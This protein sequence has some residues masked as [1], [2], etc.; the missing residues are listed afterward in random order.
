MKPLKG[1]L[2]LSLHGSP[3]ICTA[4]TTAF[5]KPR[6][7]SDSRYALVGT[8][9]EVRQACYPLTERM[10]N[11]FL[12]NLVTVLCLVAF[13]VQAMAGGL[14]VECREA[15]GTSHLEWGGCG[16]DDTGRCFAPCEPQESSDDSSAPRPCEDTPIQSHVGAA[17][18]RSSSD[19]ITFELPLPVFTI[20]SFAFTSL[21]LIIKTR[22]IEVRAAPPPSVACLRTIVI[23]I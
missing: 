17:V 15:S 6:S 7:L 2:S 8:L 12:R 23:L 1:V 22:R 18:A 14:L 21:P 16:K 3:K 13:G 10:R 11:L 4:G 20:E 5:I 19:S 9:L